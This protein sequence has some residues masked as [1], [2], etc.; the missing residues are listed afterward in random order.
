MSDL[1]LGSGWVV[2]GESELQT[3]AEEIELNVGSGLDYVIIVR[4]G[5]G[6]NFRVLQTKE[7]HLLHYNGHLTDK[8]F[9]RRLVKSHQ[10]TPNMHEAY[11]G[12]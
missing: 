8:D 3:R 7:S 9:K 1:G 2:L 4:V 6:P 11:A 10:P 12:N 5:F